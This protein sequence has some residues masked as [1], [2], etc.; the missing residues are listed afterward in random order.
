M[1]KIFYTDKHIEYIRKIS[2]DTES[3]EY[4]VSQHLRMSGV[5]WGLTS[6]SLLGI[7]LNFESFSPDIIDWIL[8]CYDQNT[9]G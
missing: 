6:L 4:L 2:K 1:S 7:D 9:G 3:F 8:S 5:Y